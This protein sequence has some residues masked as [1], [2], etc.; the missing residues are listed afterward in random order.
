VLVEAP[1]LQLY[2]VAPLA[3]IVAEEPAHI[4]ALFTATVGFGVTVTDT[5]FV[6][7]QLLVVPVT[8]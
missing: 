3:E 2:V 5:V 8:V 7:L 6:L 1:V 4:V